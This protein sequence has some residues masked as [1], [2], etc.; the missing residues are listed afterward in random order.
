MAKNSL[1]RVGSS[2]TSFRLFK[3]KLMHRIIA[4]I[5]TIVAI[6]AVMIMTSNV[7]LLIVGV[8]VVE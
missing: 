1:E 2:E 3:T 8:T 7:L 5:M 4:R 6:I